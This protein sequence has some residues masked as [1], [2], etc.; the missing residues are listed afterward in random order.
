MDYNEDYIKSVVTFVEEYCLNSPQEMVLGTEIAGALKIK[1]N[2]LDLKE[3]FGGLKRFIQSY[4]KDINVTGMAGMDNLYVHKK[5]TLRSTITEAIH[6][7]VKSP[8][9]AFSN[10][11]SKDRLFFVPQ[12]NNVIVITPTDRIDEGLREIDKVSEDQYREM[13][14]DFINQEFPNNK[15]GFDEILPKANFWFDFVKQVKSLGG[16]GAYDRVLTYRLQRLNKILDERLRSQG[17]SPGVIAQ[18][19][20]YMEAFKNRK[21]TKSDDVPHGGSRPYV[22]TLPRRDNLRRSIHVCIETMSEDQLRQ[23]WIP[24]GILLDAI[25]GH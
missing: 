4:C 21:P 15:S 9:K 24:A 17:I 1:F 5:R 23:L 13:A 2:D 10:P 19:R 14:R 18:I 11:L 7:E 12:K 25:K 20:S 22:S 3:S 6:E 16:I 8:W